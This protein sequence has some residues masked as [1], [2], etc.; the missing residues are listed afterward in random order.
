[1]SL[2]FGNLDGGA[3]Q[4][5]GTDNTHVEPSTGN[6]KRQPGHIINDGYN[7]A[8]INSLKGEKGDP[9][10]IGPPGPQGPEGPP[11]PQGPAG[12]HGPQGPKGDRGK[13][14]YEIAVD[15]GFIGTEEEWLESLK[16]GSDGS[17]GS[18]YLQE[19]EDGSFDDGAI[20]G[21]EIG[22]TTVST[23][24]DH[25]NMILLKLVPS[26]PENLSMKTLTI[27]GA[28]NTRNGADIL[29]SAGVTNNTS[30]SISPATK[31]YRIS[32]SSFVTNN[33]SS[34]GDSD[35]GV[36]TVKINGVDSGSKTLTTGS[37]V[38]VFGSLEIVS[39]V[40]YPADKP[41]FWKALTAKVSGTVTE[42]VNKV[43]LQHSISGNATPSTFV[44]DTLTTSPIV[45][46]VSVVLQGNPSF[47]YSS[48][49]PHLTTGSTLNVSGTVASLSGN[50]YLSKDIVT[51]D[52]N[53]MINDVKISPGQNAIPSILEKNHPSVNLVGVALNLNAVAH[54]ESVVRMRGSNPHGDSVFV[55]APT[56]ILYMNGTPTFGVIETGKTMSGITLKRVASPVGAK[57]NHVVTSFASSNFDSGNETSLGAAGSSHEAV[58]RGGVLRNDRTD[59]SVGYI[60]AGPDY[61][62]KDSIQ[63]ATFI[64]KKITT[65]MK[66]T[67][68]GS[69]PAELYVKLPGLPNAQPNAVNG[70]WD[71]KKNADFAPGQW[72]GSVGASDGCLTSK[73]GLVYNLTFG[74]ASTAGSN[75]NVIM[76]R[77]G[78]T[79]GQEIS[80]IKI[81]F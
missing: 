32:Q 61:S 36:L 22:Q 76:I 63:Y 5:G 48:G 16:G 4:I 75:D 42:G 71:A 77:I 38:G 65:N 62:N 11:G 27:S 64:L 30:D 70:W 60:P 3:D 6:F 31:I 49:I 46:N 53:P 80:D 25:L 47:V 43:E 81:E 29:L 13:S 10:P 7:R 54:T 57:P 9:G 40:D 73:N 35:N 52:T 74:S 20:K 28:V 33:V 24:I 67:F 56:K 8:N 44:Y 78:L 14:A 34:F 23:A 59:Y 1:M 17:V 58:I 18:I 37:D 26:S 39:E 72:P 21:W 41:G 51:I 45:S 19:P 15:Y 2:K 66:I 55:N 69:D 12:P 79:N 68:S 50:T